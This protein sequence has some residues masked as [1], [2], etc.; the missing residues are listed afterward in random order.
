MKKLTEKSFPSILRNLRTANKLP[1]RKAADLFGISPSLLQRY[2][3]G[4]VV[5]G[6]TNMEKIAD[7][8]GVSVDTL[9]GRR[10]AA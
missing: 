2:E 5:P 8:L 7:A 9:M 4:S 10:G 1:V 3:S 6:M